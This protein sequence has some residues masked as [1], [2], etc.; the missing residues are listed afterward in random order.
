MVSLKGRKS[1]PASSAAPAQK[2][3]QQTSKASAAAVK[4]LYSQANKLKD[5]NDLLKAKEAYQEIV[6]N[7]PDAENIASVQKEMEG[8]NLN[9]IFSAVEVPGK[10]VVHEV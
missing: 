9:L 8:I 4:Q 7:Y 1:S 10:S 2:S 6:T 3:A 5:D